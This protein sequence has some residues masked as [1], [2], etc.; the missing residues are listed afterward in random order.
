MA[1][2]IKL[3]FGNTLLQLLDKK[4]LEKITIND[5]LSEMG[6]SRQTFYNHFCDKNDLIQYI[7]THYILTAF[8]DDWDTMFQYNLCLI[9]YYNRILK[10]KKFMSQAIRMTCQNNLKNFMTQYLISWEKNWLETLYISKYKSSP[11]ENFY[12]ILEYHSIGCVN[13]N[14]KWI[15]QDFPLRPEEMANHITNL[16]LSI[17]KYWNM[18]DVLQNFQNMDIDFLADSD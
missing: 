3:M 7:Y 10:Y 14:L 16:R 1:I 8:P 13:M 9:D 18:E 15:E 17:L 4:K 12:F 5:L 2:D 6:A 11:P